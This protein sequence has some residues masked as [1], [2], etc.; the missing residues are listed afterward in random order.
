M[1]HLYTV[2]QC[3]NAVM[4]DS[5]LVCSLASALMFETR[6]TE[7]IYCAKPAELST[8]LSAWIRRRR[9]VENVTVSAEKDRCA[10]H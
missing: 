3:V 7:N 6:Q 5:D 10:G 8:T 4:Q 9:Q 2:W 1:M